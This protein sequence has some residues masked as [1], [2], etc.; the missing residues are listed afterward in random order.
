MSAI[1][2]SHSSKDNATAQQI[3]TWL[4]ERKF[5]SLFLDFDPQVGIHAGRDWKQELYQ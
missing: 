5:E 1:F 2:L 4:K 3:A